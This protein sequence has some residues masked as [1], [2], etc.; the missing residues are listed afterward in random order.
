MHVIKYAH[1]LCFSH[2]H[3]CAYTYLGPSTPLYPLPCSQF[4]YCEFAAHGFRED[5][6]DCQIQGTEGDGK[7]S[8]GVQPYLYLSHHQRGS[9]VMKLAI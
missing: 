7:E 4:S 8:E 5:S 6:Q 1:P 2:T 3:I 9:E